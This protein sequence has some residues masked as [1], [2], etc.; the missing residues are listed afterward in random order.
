MTEPRLEP[1]TELETLALLSEF[2]PMPKPRLYKCAALYNLAR[3][4]EGPGAIVEL[5]TFHGI[6]AIALWYGSVAE[7]RLPVYTIDA[8]TPRKGWAN[9]R[10]GPD[11]REI[12]YKN[13]ATAGILPKVLDGRPF[14]APVRDDIYDAALTWQIPISL[15]FWDLGCSN[16]VDQSLTAWEKHFKPGTII[17]LHDTSDGRLKCAEA[18]ERRGLEFD[19]WLGGVLV[20]QL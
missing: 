20:A 11:D 19:K 6:G 13:Y 1:L 12:A 2:D 18:L 3:V 14:F 4:A 5:G 9:E 10:Y 17:A 16:S 7:S 15:F 8:Y